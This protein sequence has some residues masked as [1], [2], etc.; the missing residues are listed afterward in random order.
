MNTEQ[1]FEQASRLKIRF[2]SPKGLLSVEDLWDLPLT[3]T[4]PN[5]ATLDAIAISLHKQ[6]REAT[7]TVSFV[8]PS[9]NDRQANELSLAF[10][11]V[12]HVIGVRVQERDAAQ[13]ESDRREKKQRL[14]ELIA[15][16]QDQELEGKS[17]EELR[18]MVEAL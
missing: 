14:L 18:A 2:N 12:K 5:R 17:V 3:S 8:T 1:I 11:I 4:N 16:K 9:Q 10:E 6:T 13:A 15:R 7:E